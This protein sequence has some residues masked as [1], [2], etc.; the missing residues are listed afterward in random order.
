MNWLAR[1][2]V[3]L[4]MR[5]EPPP[6]MSFRHLPQRDPTERR[7]RMNKQKPYAGYLDRASGEYCMNHNKH[8]ARAALKASAQ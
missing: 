3:Y 1:R 7:F 6:C 2:N 8:D 5:V 4:M